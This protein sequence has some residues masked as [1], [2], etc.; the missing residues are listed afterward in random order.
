MIVRSNPDRDY[1]K[2]RNAILNDERISFRAKGVL[3]YLLTRPDDWKVSERQLARVGNEGVTAVRAALK[4]LELAGYIVRRRMRGEGG[5]FEWESLVFDIPRAVEQHLQEPCSE[6]I[7]AEN[8][9]CTENLSM[10][11]PPCSENLICTA[12]PCSENI[13]MEQGPCSGFPCADKP[14]VDNRAEII[15]VLPITD[16]TT[17]TAAPPPSQPTQQAQPPAPA[18]PTPA[19]LAANYQTVLK[20]YHNEIGVVTPIIEEEIKAQLRQCPVEWLTKAIGIA[21][22]RN[23]RRWSYVEGI[24]HRWQVEGFDGGQDNLSANAKGRSN[25]QSKSTGYGRQEQRGGTSPRKGKS[26]D[27]IDEDMAQFIANFVDAR[28]GTT[29]LAAD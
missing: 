5:R 19:Q 13:S 24:L 20:A 9:P 12:E 14:C 6:N 28:D 23:N 27:A 2:I 10:E 17:A 21:V 7:S 15:T 18:K 29:A 11:Q 16:P 4:E 1:A 26:Q 3:I 8:E 22:K 25:G